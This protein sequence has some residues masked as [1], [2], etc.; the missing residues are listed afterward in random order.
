MLDP[1][2]PESGFEVSFRLVGHIACGWV[3]LLVAHILGASRL[4]TLA[5]HAGGVRQ[6]AIR[7]VVYGLV[8]RALCFQLRGGFCAQL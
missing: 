1:T 4:V 5:K 8:G 3:P 6:I 2:D 7:E